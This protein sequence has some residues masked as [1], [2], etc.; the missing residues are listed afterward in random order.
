MNPVQLTPQIAAWLQ[1]DQPNTLEILPSLFSDSSHDIVLQHFDDH[2]DVIKAVRDEAQGSTFWQGMQQL[3]GITLNQQIAQFEHNYPWL[4]QQ[5]PLPLPRWLH[6]FY[7]AQDQACAV[8]SSFL[9]GQTLNAEA[10]QRSMVEQLARHLANWHRLTHSRFGTLQHPQG[11]RKAWPKQLQRTLQ[12]LPEIT[13]SERQ[14]KQQSMQQLAEHPEAFV[15]E[16]F[17][18]IMPDLRWDQFLVEDGHLALTDLDAVV[19]GPVA[20]EWVLLEALLT[21]QQASWFLQAYPATP[22]T[23]ASVRQV[24]R[25]V[26]CQLQVFGDQN[27]QAWLNLPTWFD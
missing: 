24:Y 3:F 5:T 4:A 1:T 17:S 27:T 15:P 8:R 25:A 21:E 26:L 2:S 14:L 11:E 10:V 18:V 23:L 22:P 20:L 12:S 7:N 19:F 9:S 16:Q 6:T 13:P